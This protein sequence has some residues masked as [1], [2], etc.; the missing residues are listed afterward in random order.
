[1]YTINRRKHLQTKF[2]EIEQ[3]QHSLLYVNVLTGSLISYKEPQL[4]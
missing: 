1:M 3:F 4:V 2:W